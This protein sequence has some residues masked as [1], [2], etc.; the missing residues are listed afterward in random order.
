MSCGLFFPW[1]TRTPDSH[2]H[3]QKYTLLATDQ[4][5]FQV[6]M[7]DKERWSRKQA[8]EVWCQVRISQMFAPNMFHNKVKGKKIWIKGK[9]YSDTY[10]LREKSVKQSRQEKH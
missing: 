10:T 1:E 9:T 2:E 3:H 7:K 5:S 4:S 6:L 8:K